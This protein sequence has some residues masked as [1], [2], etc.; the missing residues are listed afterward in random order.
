MKESGGFV[1]KQSGTL[2]HIGTLAIG[3][4][5]G[6]GLC[7]S[8]SAAVKILAEPS[9]NAIYVDGQKVEL[10]A[11]K[12]L[13]SN[14]LKLREVGEAVGFNVYWDSENGCVQVDTGSA[15][16]GVAPAGGRAVAPAETPP[17]TAPAISAT[18]AVDVDAAKQEIID[19]TN[20][21]RAE[22]GVAA[23]QKDELLMQAAQVRA[24]EMA[25][26]GIYSHTRPDGSPS[27]TVT[28]CEYTP[29]NIHRISDY[30]LT[31]WKQRLADA[32][33]GSWAKSPGHLKNMINDELSSIGVGL[34]RGLNASGEDC[35]YCV[36][37]FIYNGYLV[38]WV[39]DPILK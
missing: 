24:E 38:T 27:N 19:L 32:V 21:L 5:L 3:M 12:I 9:W 16:T 35:W 30:T 17:Q 4:A 18:D 28:N 7:I 39:D 13:G 26:S 23:L 10:E 36:Q 37:V 20:A 31:Q 22:T 6:A 15:Y 8:A 29:E 11:Y 34:A 2:K 25:S 33:V 1:M 14:Y